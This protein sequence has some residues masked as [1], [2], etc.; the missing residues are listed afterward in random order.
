MRYG[1]V[2]YEFQVWENGE[3]YASGTAATLDEVKREAANYLMQCEY[4]PSVKFFE[5]REIV[6]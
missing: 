2:E 1:E 3:F 6:E 5:R 4:N